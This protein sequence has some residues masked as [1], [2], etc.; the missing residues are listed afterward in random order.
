[1][2]KHGILNPQ[3]SRLI[4]EL[5]HT[6]ALVVADAGLPIPAGVERVD[7]ALTGGIP[8][9]MEVLNAILDE[10]QVERAVIA[11]EMQ[12]KSPQLYV[13]VGAALKNCPTGEVPHEE[14]KL[15]TTQVRAIVRTGEFTPYA[16][17]ILYSGVVF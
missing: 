10:M 15:L 8:S 3:L 17:I 7:L 9:F 14:F 13:Q 11:Q 5:G 1:M 6:D 2:K 4:A 12:A 16:N